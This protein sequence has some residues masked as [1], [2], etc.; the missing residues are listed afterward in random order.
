[1]DDSVT[2]RLSVLEVHNENLIDLLRE[3][4]V[5]LFSSYPASSGRGYA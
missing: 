2:I 4:G 3:P 5:S 1:M